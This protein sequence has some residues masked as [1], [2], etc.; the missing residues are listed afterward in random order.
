M[1]TSKAELVRRYFNA[2]TT[3]DRKFFEDHLADEF[4]FT[5]PCDDAIDKAAYFERCWP[6]SEW[7]KQHDIERIFVQGDEAFVTYRC[8]T[9]DGKEFRNTEFFVFTGDRLRQVHVYF[10]GSYKDGRFVRQQ[11]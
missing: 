7:I 9:R 11:P 2:Y 3:K 5:S 10:G 4:T 6:N 8:S 1:S